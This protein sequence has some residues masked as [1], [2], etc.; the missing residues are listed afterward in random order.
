MVAR[1]GVLLFYLI[2]ATAGF[3]AEPIVYPAEGQNQAQQSEDEGAC[4][5]WARDRTGFNPLGD[6]S[7]PG[8]VAEE[9]RGGAVRGAARGAAVGAIVGD[10]DDAAKG[11]AAGAAIGRMRQNRRNREARGAAESETA[12][13]QAQNAADRGEFDRAYGACLE[14]RGYT[15]K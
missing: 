1:T 3:A 10:S 12:A 14:G 5:V 15:V 9:K 13:V 11:A 8:P 7:A 4:F 6:Q 2:F